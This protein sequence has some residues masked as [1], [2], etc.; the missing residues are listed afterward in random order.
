MRS[1]RDAA[2][3]QLVPKQASGGAAAGLPLLPLFDAVLLPGGFARVTIP[4]SWRASAPLVELL[5]QQQGDAD[6]LVAAVPFLT[7]KPSSSSSAA[8]GGR[9][10]DEG[11]A[12]DPLDLDKLHHTG[13]AAR[14]LQLARRTQ[15][16]AERG[17]RRGRPDCRGLPVFSTR[18]LALAHHFNALW[19]C[20]LLIHACSPAAG[21]CCWR[22]GAACGCAACTCPAGRASFM[23]H[24]WTSLTTCRPPLARASRSAPAAPAAAA[25]VAAAGLAAA[26]SRRSLPTSFS[27]WAGVP[28]RLPALASSAALVH[29]L[30]RGAAQ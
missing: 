29:K 21:A 18:C 8:G 23:R 15:V 6:V 12:D 2:A 28:V 5:L 25:A 7:G 4:A 17:E 26:R 10:E 30:W 14:V 11:L 22:G 20:R 24:L 1:S 13:T 16:G 9:T 3:H 27:R 19:C